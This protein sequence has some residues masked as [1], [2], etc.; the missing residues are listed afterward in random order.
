MDLPSEIITNI[1]SRLPW[2]TIIGCKRVCKKWNELLSS[3]EFAKFH[4]S[5]S[6]PQVLVLQTDPNGEYLCKFVENED[7]FQRHENGFLSDQGLKFDPK[8]FISSPA[9][10][11]I[12]IKGSVDGLLCLQYSSKIDDVIYVCNPITRQ[13]TSLP[14]LARILEYV[15]F[16]QYGFGVSSITGQYKVIHLFQKSIH[17]V[18]QCVITKNYQ[19][20]FYDYLVYTLGTGYWRRIP[21][22]SPFGR[23][24]LSFGV[25]LNGNLHGLVQDSS[26]SAISISC[27]D[28]EDESFK[29]FCPPPYPLRLVWFTCCDTLGV[30]DDCLCICDSTSLSGEGGLVFWTMREYGVEESWTR[31][32]IFLGTQ[33]CHSFP[34][35]VVYPI[36]GYKN[37]DILFSWQHQTLFYHNNKTKTSHEVDMSAPNSDPRFR[38]KTMLHNS[39]FLSLESFQGEDVISYA[40]M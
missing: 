15:N 40:D 37:G 9:D 21:R 26:K 36:K 25:Y 5:V 7:N 35:D 27:F 23:A 29:P 8:A 1:L 13:Y 32:Y 38:F 22:N 17:R 6:T 30:L 3:L 20:E 24:H 18:R 16:T 2:R 33:I 11:R 28:L 34:H 10:Y 4:L 39:S 12:E 19:C 31:Q 14:R